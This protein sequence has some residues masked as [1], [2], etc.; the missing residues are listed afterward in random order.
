MASWM[1]TAATYLQRCYQVTQQDASASSAYME[2]LDPGQ[3]LS[4]IALARQALQVTKQPS[5]HPPPRHARV[6]TP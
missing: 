2:G 6:P 1:A 4:S 3:R 5:L